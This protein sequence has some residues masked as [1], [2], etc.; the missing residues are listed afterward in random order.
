[1]SFTFWSWN[2]NSGDTGGILNDDWTT[3][4][5]TKQSFLDP[6]LIAPDGGSGPTDPPPT[7]TVSCR[8]TYGVNDW[9]S[10]FGATLSIANTGTSAISNWTLG[11]T[12]PGNQR[13]TNGWNATWTQAA[14]SANVT[15]TPAGHN[16]LIPAGQ[17]VTDLGFN[18]SYT[19]TNGRPT[20]FT[21]NGRSCTVA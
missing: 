17:S 9:G 8:V 3:V 10:G 13:I 6:Y 21:V 2:P 20:A 1:M 14:G 12:F 15:A 18:A 4:N 5:T 19:G 7:P 16:G 11:F